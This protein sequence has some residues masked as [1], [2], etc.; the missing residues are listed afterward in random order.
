MPHNVNLSV[1][2][3]RGVKDPGCK[4]WSECTLSVSSGR[5]GWAAGGSTKISSTGCLDMEVEEEDILVV[6]SIVGVLG[7]C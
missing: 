6:I 5:G 4:E 2:G 7:L 1:L 3:M